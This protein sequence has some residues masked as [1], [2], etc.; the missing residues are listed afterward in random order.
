MF[1]TSNDLLACAA[2]IL[3]IQEAYNISARAIA[4]GHLHPQRKSVEFGADECYELGFVNSELEYHEQVREWM[5]EAWKRMNPPYSY[6]GLLTR[7]NVLEHLA[8]AEYQVLTP[9][10]EHVEH[11]LAG[12]C[13]C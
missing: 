10:S 13:T 12:L 7:V 4:D 8:W 1:P 2:A 5:T 3:R 6:S 11:D 9:L